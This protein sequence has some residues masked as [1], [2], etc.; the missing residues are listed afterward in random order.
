M[1]AEEV[2]TTTRAVRKRLDLGR[3]VPM[4]LIAECIEVALQAPSG[5][6]R[7]GWHFVVV[8]D[9]EKKR[10]IADYY[11]QSWTAYRSAQSWNYAKE[12]PRQQRVGAVVDSAQYLADHFH[13]VPVHVIP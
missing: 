7:Q 13:E 6:N 11:R 10:Q 3:P 5:G 12:D 1:D 9:S 2:L 4:E 8:T